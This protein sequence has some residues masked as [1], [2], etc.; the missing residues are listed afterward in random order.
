MGITTENIVKKIKT[1]ARELGFLDCGISQAQ[2]LAEEK[3]RLLNWL[4]NEMNGEMAYMNNHIDKRL[5]PRLLVEN[6]R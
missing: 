2:F 3:P 1:K 4:S 5:D 6:A